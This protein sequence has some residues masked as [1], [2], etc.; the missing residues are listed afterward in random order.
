MRP[1]RKALNIAVIGAGSTYTPEMV[2]GFL[3][4]SDSLPV[5]ELRLMDID[6]GK[7]GIVGGLSRRMLAAAGHPARLIE[8][9]ELDAALAGAD[10]V[11]AQLRVGGLEAR[12]SDEKIPLRHGLI[13][14]E[15]TGI[16]GFFNALRTIPVVL[17]IARRMEALCPG[18]FLLN[19]ANPSG[20]VTEAVLKN[21]SVRAIG[22]CN[23]PYNML[24]ESR[25]RVP[26]GLGEPEI[27]YLG[28]NHLSWITS[29]R[30]GGHDWLAEQLSDRGDV[31]RPA[32]VPNFG[33]EPDLL[34]CLGVEPSVYLGYFYYREKV[35]AKL[36]AESQSRGEVCKRIEAELLEL[37]RQPE[38]R[39]KPALLEQRGGAYYSEVAVSLI[40]AIAND[41]GEIHVAG[42][43][44][45]GALEFME[46]DDVVELSCLVDAEGCHPRPLPCFGD[47]H[48]IGLMRQVKVYERFAV[49]AAVRSD[50]G[51][52]M[53]ALLA[54][55]LVGDWNLAKGCFEEMLEANRP[56]LPGFFAR[57]RA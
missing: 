5:A 56:Y 10:F 19:F 38:L 39:E 25:K 53:R 50:R 16:G 43:R 11:L 17:G 15:T 44:N 46:A 49:E 40:D 9:T 27:T 22:L 41:R 55:P 7:L 31:Y 21:S 24:K 13:G 35:L 34:S 20:L 36:R 33:F 12:I 2:E 26:D 18:A 28:L 14:Q 57:S 47:G 30:A 32:N 42:V 51:A 1:A 3:R 48:I 37:Y 45:G 23:V 6:P 8:T 52:A 54:H 29:V 4:R